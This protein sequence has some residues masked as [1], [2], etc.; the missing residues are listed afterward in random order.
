MAEPPSLKILDK[1]MRILALFA[2]ESPEWRLTDL[3]AA[4]ALPKSTVHRIV[5][6]LVQHE[7]LA[8]DPNTHRFRLGLG[9]IEL[10]HRAYEGLELRRV[11]APVLNRVAAA[12]G[13]T[14][15]LQV[16]NQQH[17]QVVCVERAQLQSGLRLILEVG[18]T[19]PLHAG[20][21]SKILLAYLSA[22]EIDAVI[23]RGLPALTRH[24]ITEPDRLRCELQ[25]IRRQ[26]YAVSFEETDEGAAGVSVPVRAGAG[27]VV[28]GLTIAGPVIRMSRDT[29]SGYLR[30]A[31]DGAREIESKL[32]YRRPVASGA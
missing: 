3:A 20:S 27:Q 21:S 28:A 10:G 1:T 4:V 8:Q 9:A 32:G 31:L 26:G 14:V 6:V 30:L 16:L 11:A 22:D 17:D 5:R 12:S 2:P 23:A 18:S 24:T 13:E 7:F 29:I 19:A 25:T 15:P